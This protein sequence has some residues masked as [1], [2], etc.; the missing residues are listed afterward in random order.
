L[1]VGI[2]GAR[3]RWR[4][5]PEPR[6]S[7]GGAAPQLAELQSLPRSIIEQRKDE[8][9]ATTVALTQPIERITAQYGL[10]AAAV[11]LLVGVQVDHA[12]AG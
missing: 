12:G 8:A 3:D 4:P 5:Q 2:S 6:H 1:P 7:P 9:G 11:T 10:T